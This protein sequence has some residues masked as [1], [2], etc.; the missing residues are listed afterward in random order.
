MLAA[1][2]TETHAPRMTD[3]GM[4]AQCSRLL[5][6]NHSLVMSYPTILKE[7]L[8]IRLWSL[9]RRRRRGRLR[10]HR[11]RR[12]RRRYKRP[13][14][15]TREQHPR[16]HSHPCLARRLVAG[17]QCAR[18]SSC[19]SSG[20]SQVGPVVSATRLTLDHLVREVAH[21]E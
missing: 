11:R 16:N 5:V 1:R 2:S 15:G 18:L 17:D 8:Y 19:P 9:T 21:I 7:V 20:C 6:V 12:S 13:E 4:I 14:K 3:K 10:I